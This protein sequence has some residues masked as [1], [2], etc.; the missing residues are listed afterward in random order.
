MEQLASVRL[1]D[2]KTPSVRS[3]QLEPYSL[4][5]DVVGVC[6]DLAYKH[7]LGSVRESAI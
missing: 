3:R 1:R 5:L 6:S 2:T 7:K 4:C